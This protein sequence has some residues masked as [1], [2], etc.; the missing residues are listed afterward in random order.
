MLKVGSDRK[1]NDNRERG[2]LSLRI[3]VAREGPR[4]AG[5]SRGGVRDE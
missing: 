1:K 4:V 5:S 2:A 3:R